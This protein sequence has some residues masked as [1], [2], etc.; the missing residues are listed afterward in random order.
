MTTHMNPHDDVYWTR[1]QKAQYEREGLVKYPDT[2]MRMV[3]QRL[4]GRTGT[5]DSAFR[6][7]R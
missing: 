3:R 5:H 1:E 7:I 6:Q 2:I 4:G